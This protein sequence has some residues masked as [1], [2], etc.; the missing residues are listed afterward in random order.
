MARLKG[1]SSTRESKYNATVGFFVGI[2]ML[3]MA[4]TAFDFSKLPL[5]GKLFIIV[6]IGAALASIYQS[7]RNAFSRKNL[8]HEVTDHD[9]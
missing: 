5:V 6:W 3:I 8:H 1:T 7:Y 4:L 2:G 9:V